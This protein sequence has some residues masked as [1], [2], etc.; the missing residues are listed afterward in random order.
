[1]IPIRHP[2][3]MRVGMKACRRRFRLQPFAHRNQKAIAHETDYF[4]VRT[5]LA[6][7]K[8]Q[9]L[10]GIPGTGYF[11]PAARAY[12]NSLIVK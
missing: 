3:I 7:V 6:L 10:R 12:I 5:K 11:G 1:M 9:K 2:E 8:H 4:G